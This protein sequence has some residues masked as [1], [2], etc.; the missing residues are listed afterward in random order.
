[1]RDCVPAG[2]LIVAFAFERRHLD[3]RAERGLD[4]THR[5]F[6]KQIVAVALENLVRLDVQHHIQIARR[7]AAK[8]RLAISRRAQ[9][10]TGV[11]ARRNA[12]FYF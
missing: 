4:E 11:H 1:V 9:A 7:P 6:A 10:R 5:H 2:I 3:F 12:Q 8:T